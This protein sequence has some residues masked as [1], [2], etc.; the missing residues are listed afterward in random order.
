MAL[1]L[2]V[3]VPAFAV[4]GDS[5]TG[6][7][8]SGTVTVDRGT[9]I[10]VALSPDGREMVMD[11]Q[12]VLWRLPAAGGR[13]T[14]ITGNLADPALPDWSPDG[15]RIALQS[16]AGGNF[17]IWTMRPD[18]SG[19][20]QLTSG[21]YDEREPRWSP[22]GASIAFSSDR[23]GSY[24]IWVLDLRSGDLERRTDSPGEEFQP[25][26]SPDGEEIAFVAAERIEEEGHKL[27]ELYELS[28]SAIDAV[29]GSGNRRTLVTEE[30]GSIASPSW[31]P[32][33]ERVAY[34][35][36]GDTESVLKVDGEQVSDEGEDV[37]RF[38]AEWLSADRLVYTADGR[39]RRRDLTQGTL[40]NV[41]FE[42]RLS[43]DRPAYRFKDRDFD[44]REPR[45]VRGVVSP[46]LA[47][48]A[49]RV[50]FVALNDVWLMRIGAP[51]RRLTDDA[52]LEADPAFSA[53]G[54]YL[55]YSSDRQGSEDIYIR[56]LA[57]GSERRLT[58]E[59]G[60][61]VAAA[62]SP[63]GSRIAFQDEEGATFTADV[64][65]GTVEQ[66]LDPVWEPGRPTWGPNGDTLALAALK[67][68]SARFREGTSQIVTL[69][70]GSNSPRYVDP[71]PFKSL[72]NRVDSGPVWSPDGRRMAFVIESRLW[73]M[74]VDASGRPTGPPRVVSDEVAGAPSFSGDS[75][76]LLYLSNGRLRLVRLDGGAPRPVPLP[77]RWRPNLPDRGW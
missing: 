62:W 52:Y 18:G 73:T 42:A 40:S 25:S 75:R 31:S 66:V 71:I 76:Q 72:S 17:H 67:P 8:E 15:E 34:T 48:G 32:D 65:S 33:G 55:A 61:E 77:L 45:R 54:R 47:P 19:R 10:A 59:P 49:R 56:A 38:P 36:Y 29:D 16:Y 39:I 74:P 37:F 4:G 5:S 1:L 69:E 2:L 28:A 9:N 12:G 46:V 58:S 27:G 21:R 14:R 57:S 20:R 3:A 60:A 51:P 23:G 24:D 41:P 7:G 43:F 22:D 11:L 26:W 64:G 6:G 63:D 13:A 50:A 68:F 44:S 35:L 70:L 30:E 53:D